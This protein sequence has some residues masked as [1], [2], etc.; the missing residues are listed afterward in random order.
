MVSVVA[1]G[2]VGKSS[3]V[4]DWVRKLVGDGGRG[5]RMVFGH[6]FYSQGSREDAGASSDEFMRRALEFFGDDDPAAGSPWDK[7]E[8][9]AKLVRRE[10]A[11]LVLDGLE[12]LQH[13]PT[14]GDAGRLKDPAVQALIRELAASNPGLCI[15]TTRERVADIP[16]APE[17]PLEHLS[18]TAGAALLAALGVRGTQSE[19]ESASGEVHGHGLA[20]RLL[21]T[22]L[23]R[24]CDGDVRRRGEV[25]L[26]EADKVQGGHAFKIIEK[27][28][29]WFGEGIEVAILRL[30]GLF[31][32]PAESGC[33]R[34]LRAEPVIVGLTEPLVACS[35][36]DWNLALSTLAD[37]GLVAKADPCDKDATLDAHPL[38][39]EYFG[40]ELAEQFPEAAKEAHRRLY[41]HLKQAAPYRPDTLR[42]MM[43]LYH[44][45]F[46][47][48][49]AGLHWEVWWKV[50]DE[51]IL[52]GEESFSIR[53]LC[54]L[55]TELYTFASYFDRPWYK[56][57]ENI[58]EVEAA[59][60]LG[61]V[62]HLLRALGRIDESVASVR[63]AVNYSKDFENWRNAAIGASNLSGL[64]LNL[65]NIAGALQFGEECVEHAD[66]SQVEFQRIVNRARLADSLHQSGQRSAAE[67]GFRDAE[68]LQSEYDGQ[69]H[70]VC[71][72]RGFQYCDLL[73]SENFTESR[74]C[75]GAPVTSLESLDRQPVFLAVRQWTEISLEFLEHHL[76]VLDL[77]LAYLTVART[78]LLEASTIGDVKG[79]CSILD[80]AGHNLDKSIRLLREAEH[81][82]LIVRGLLS[83]VAMQRVLGDISAINV[84]LSE[85]ETIAERSSMLLF[86]VDAAIERCRWHLAQGDR[87]SARE[88]LEYAKALVKK[89]E[90]PY[91]PHVPMWAGWRP[92]VYEGVRYDNVFKEGEIV[93]YH[94]RNPEIAAL[95]RELG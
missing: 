18:D 15:I 1:F 29:R 46:H 63:E 89:T 30:L 86:Q 71:S 57:N 27:Y 44:A 87:K 88:L 37:C 60:I 2:G 26:A 52:R 43:P 47:G 64:L 11:V 54:A 8:R 75:V 22:Y 53:R 31:N 59:L 40:K 90:R 24:A 93:G 79:R 13:P 67:S 82:E 77:G 12:P 17:L 33:I 66:R 95:G 85:A 23:A 80:Q 70:L 56:I 9:L 45:V 62:S 39:R 94:R 49:A 10:M 65:G 34:A 35:E 81:Q 32:R 16:T 50:H 68:A 3:L 58:N 78:Y 92:L 6:S 83:K 36:W 61:G 14:A 19:L 48:C 4:A 42:E 51:R 28:V 41:E 38:V 91:V 84:V 7:G 25:E 72:L 5:A 73:L 74:P 69:H 21:G 76:P 20:L 55:G